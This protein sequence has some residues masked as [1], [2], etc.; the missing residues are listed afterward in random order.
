MTAVAQPSPF[1]DILDVYVL[2]GKEENYRWSMK[3]LSQ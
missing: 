2:P 1:G 3:G